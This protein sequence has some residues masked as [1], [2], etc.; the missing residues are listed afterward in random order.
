[1]MDKICFLDIDG[2][3][4]SEAT[5]RMESRK[6][7]GIVDNTIFDAVCCS[8]FQYVLEK[9]PGVKVV[10]SST[11]KRL[12][13]LDQLKRFFDEQYIDSGRV[14]GITPSMLSATRGEEISMWLRDHPDVTEFVAIDDDTDMAPIESNW[15]QTDCRVGLT[16]PLALEVIKRLKGN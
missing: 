1:M 6:P 7:G 3:L 2:V 4:N 11:W 12:Y 9:V 13:P 16:M 10:I 5:F 15:V 8:N 14:I